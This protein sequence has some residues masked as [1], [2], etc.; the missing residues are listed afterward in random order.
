MTKLGQISGIFEWVFNPDSKISKECAKTIHRLLTTQTAFK[1]KFLYNSLKYIHLKNKDFVKFLAFEEDVQNS[2]FCVASMNSDGYIR[3]EALTFL[4]KT[5]TQST[6]PFILFR[7]ADWVPRI[8]QKVERE[9]RHLIQKQKPEFLI[10]NHKIL[11][12]ILKVERTNL[13]EIHQGITEFIFSDKN[14]HQIIQDIDSYEERSRY[15]IFKNLIKRHKLD[16]QISEK[17]LTDKSYLIRLLAVRNINLIERPEILRRLLKD[18]NQKIRNYAINRISENQLSLFKTELNSLIFDNSSTIRAICRT[19]LLK[20][21]DQNYPEK[22][23]QKI[24]KNPNPGS[25]IGLSEMGERTDIDRLSGFLKSDSPKLRA[26]ALFAVSNI[27]YDNAKVQAFELLHDS[28]NTVKKTCYNVISNDKSSD[29]L[30]KLRNIYD[31]GSNETKR[32]VLKIINKY[33]GWDIVGD[34]LKGI[35]EGDEKINQTAFAFLKGWYN[36]SIRLGTKQKDV[37]QNYV[38]GIY[39]DLNIGRLEL[40]SDIKNI[41]NK[42]PFIFGR[43]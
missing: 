41:T 31:I 11:D 12:W 34:F 16:G 28:S 19:L 8:R 43:K 13:L 35:N 39:R 22:Y 2:L 15:F 25:I 5:P 27:D 10:R 38:I 24:S 42:I 40:P 18:K 37:D 7:L 1:N 17:I 20:I 29:D 6:F 33:G 4:I 30:S 32:F 21:S 14:V 26:A 9:I 36:Y 3:E 23:R